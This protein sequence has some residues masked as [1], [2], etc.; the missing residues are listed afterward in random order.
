M[1]PT[2]SFVGLPS[3]LS[4]FPAAC[5]APQALAFF[6]IESYLPYLVGNLPVDAGKAA[7]KAAELE[8]VD[9]DNP[10]DKCYGLMG[11]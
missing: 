10:A 9:H 5:F 7:S 8:V 6:H 3:F 4:A 1:I 11:H 2:S